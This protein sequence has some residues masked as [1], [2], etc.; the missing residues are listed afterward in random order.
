MRAPSANAWPVMRGPS[1]RKARTGLAALAVKTP[2]ST[3]L[4]SAAR[5][6]PTCSA[7]RCGAVSERSTALLEGDAACHAAMRAGCAL[8]AA[9]HRAGASSRSGR[10]SSAAA[11]SCAAAAALPQ[12]LRSARW[13]GGRRPPC[14]ASRSRRRSSRGRCTRARRRAAPSPRSPARGPA[15]APR[16]RKTP[17]SCAA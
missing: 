3:L 13:A 15:R 14:H 7:P 11:A 8:S 6:A 9:L 2:D 17:Q 10:A 5:R 1:M 4:L 12:L 16:C